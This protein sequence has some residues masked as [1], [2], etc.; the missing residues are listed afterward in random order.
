MDKIRLVIYIAFA[1]ILSIYG[2]INYLNTP[3]GD[4]ELKNQIV[5]KNKKILIGSLL[6]ALFLAVLGVL[7]YFSII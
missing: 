1:V 3:N 7:D 4:D 2:I 5:A 6:G